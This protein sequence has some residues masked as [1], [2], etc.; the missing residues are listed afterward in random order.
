MALFCPHVSSLG[1]RDKQ[2]SILLRQSL[3]FSFFPGIHSRG[4]FLQNAFAKHK[5][6][7]NW[8]HYQRNKAPDYYLLIQEWFIMKQHLRGQLLQHPVYLKHFID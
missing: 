1:L 7:M 2:H 8:P 3:F 4:L 5:R 6:K